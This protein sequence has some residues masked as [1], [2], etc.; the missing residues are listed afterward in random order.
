VICFLFFSSYHY[1]YTCLSLLNLSKTFCFSPSS[2]SYFLF[3]C[4]FFLHLLLNIL[5]FILIGFV[6]ISMSS[7]KSVR[8]K[9]KE[10]FKGELSVIIMQYYLFLFFFLLFS[11][12]VYTIFLVKLFSFLF[13]IVHELVS[14]KKLRS[15]TMCPV[16][17]NVCAYAQFSP[18]VICFVG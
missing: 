1:L 17:L 15:L 8:E 2:S 9:K 12:C 18:I 11:S 4:L 5:F 16:E 6:V 13:G 10:N 7:R 3:R 14:N